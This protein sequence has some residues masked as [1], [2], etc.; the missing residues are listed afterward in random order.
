MFVDREYRRNGRFGAYL[1]VRRNGIVEMG[2]SSPILTTWKDGPCFHHASLAQL[3][4]LFLQFT[5]DLYSNWSPVSDF[6]C[7]LN[8]RGTSRA[9]LAGFPPD[10]RNRSR[11][12][13][14]VVNR[15][16]ESCVRNCIQIQLKQRFQYR[17]WN[18]EGSR[19]V[20]GNTLNWATLHSFRRQVFGR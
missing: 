2:L 9:E 5:K 12:E 17:R 18:R 19:S 8:L 11:E 15:T 4:V 10:I 1:V 20:L 6:E 13:I 3:I 16:C 14:T 7:S